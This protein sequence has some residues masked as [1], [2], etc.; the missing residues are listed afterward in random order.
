MYYLLQN[1]QNY[2]KMYEKYTYLK[3]KYEA[4]RRKIIT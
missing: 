3:D 1:T 4:N 2:T